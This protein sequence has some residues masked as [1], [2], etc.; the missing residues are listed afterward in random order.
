[1][2]VFK[3]LVK[4]WSNGS[5]SFN[6]KL[7][8]KKDLNDFFT[9]R[10][11][12]K[13]PQLI[14]NYRTIYIVRALLLTKKIYCSYILFLFYVI[15]SI[16]IFNFSV[17]DCIVIFIIFKIGR[18]RIKILDIRKMNNRS[19]K[20]VHMLTVLTNNCLFLSFIFSLI[21][22]SLTTFFTYHYIVCINIKMF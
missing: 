12:L 8:D 20:R 1:M 17:Y 2:E 19:G 9:I 21:K 22:K 10:I 3:K 18:K 5:I 15:P 16:I 7:V 11:I 14:Q 6:K 13:I 4:K